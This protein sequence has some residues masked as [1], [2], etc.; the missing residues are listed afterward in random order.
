[1]NGDKGAGLREG[2]FPQDA[3]PAS[4]VMLA[5][6]LSSRMRGLLFRPAS[7]DL[8]V[9]M[10]CR[11]IHTFGMQYAIDVAFIDASGRVIRSVRD[12][13]PNRRLKEP[14]AVAVLERCAIPRELWFEEGDRVALG[15]YRRTV[16]AN[17]RVCGQTAPE[18]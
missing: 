8:M 13:L 17:E 5:T 12:V 18:N 2:C 15:Q 9:L 4:R 10:P 6:K 11:D 16:L 14:S 3:F 1:M 7:E